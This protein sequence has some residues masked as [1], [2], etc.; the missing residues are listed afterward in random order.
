MWAQLEVVATGLQAPQKVITTPSGNLLVSETSMSLR[1]G[2]ISFVTPAG[3]RRSFMEGLPSGV[4][5]AGGGSGPTAMALR[6]RTLYV[7][8]GGGDAER[9][10]QTPGVAIHNPEGVSSAIFASV[11]RLQLDRDI[12]SISGT[13]QMTPA[14]EQVLRDGGEVRMEDGSGASATVIVLTRL[15]ISEPDPNTVY[16]FSNP[17]G[18]ALSADG[19]TLYL[20]DA[21]MNALVRI[22]TATGRWERIVRFPPS[23]NSTPVGP[24]VID[25]VPT[26]VRIY[27]EQLLVSFLTGFPFIPGSARVLAVNP[28]TRAVEPFIFGLT[29]VT[30]VLW[31][32]TSGDR[33]QFFVLEFSQNQSQQPP[34]PGRLLRYDTPMPEVVS[35]DLRAPVS[36]ALDASS[37]TLYVLELTGRLLRLRLN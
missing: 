21:S 32:P 11:L 22:N 35:A 29:S 33:P 9:R 8:I 6:D 10:S 23:Q 19:S 18:F 24:P 31:R 36:L 2:R 7:A 28:T 5:V 1:S 3:A 20:N 16:R 34:P 30:D 15:P 17:W 12:D 37:N 26:S 27:G 14:H 13:F 25:A 4:E